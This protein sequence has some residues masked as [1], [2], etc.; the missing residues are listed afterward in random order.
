MALINITIS[1]RPRAEES[2][3]AQTKRRRWRRRAVAVLSVLAVVGVAGGIAE[4]TGG[5]SSPPSSYTAIAPTLL[6]ST[7]LANNGTKDVLAAGVDG[8]PVAATSVQ[9]SVTVLSG[10]AAGLLYIYPTGNTLPASANVRWLTGQ[11]VTIPVT[12]A[13][14]TGGKI[15]LL[16]ETGTVSV[17]ISIVGYYEALP[18]AGVAV[19]DAN[20][21]LLGTLVT[22]DPAGSGVTLLTPNDYLI[23]IGWDGTIAAAQI[24]YV[25]T[26][27]LPCSGA[28]YLSDGGS[29]DSVRSALILN[30]S[31]SLDELM[32]P[33]GTNNIAQSSSIAGVTGLDNPSCTSSAPAAETGWHL[34]G[35][36][37][38]SAGLPAAAS[39]GSV[40]GPIALSS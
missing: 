40:A 5:T 19:K 16:S 9:L 21:T 37:A 36:T 29:G 23:T 14:G 22:V 11:T 39:G 4:A 17:K 24:Y 20:G 25:G 12:T 7:S 31:A 33:I 8:V 10:T 28:A 26:A 27:L 30:W 3:P 38:S 35:I 15:H 18:T 6:I 32:V 13:I 34:T 1:P 2:T